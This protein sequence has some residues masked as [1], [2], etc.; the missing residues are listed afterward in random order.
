MP[1]F[2][3]FYVSEIADTENFESYLLVL[4]LY[5]NKFWMSHFGKF[6]VSK[7]IKLLRNLIR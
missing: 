7:M 2:K 4:Y 3:V 5:R 6:I 1:R